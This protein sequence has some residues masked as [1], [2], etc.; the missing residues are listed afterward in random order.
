MQYNALVLPILLYNCGT[1]SLTKKESN[2]L[3]AFHRKQLRGIMG[4]KWEDKITNRELYK[5]TNCKPISE[6]IKTARWRLFGH[7]LRRDRDIP[8]QVAM[9]EYY[10]LTEKKFPGKTPTNLISVINQDLKATT[11]SIDKDH[12]YCTKHVPTELA[13]LADLDILRANALDRE[14]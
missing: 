11:S 1:W 2:S 14:H 4:I 12:T 13:S 3:D 5:K 10:N 7:I 9:E 6:L 8:A